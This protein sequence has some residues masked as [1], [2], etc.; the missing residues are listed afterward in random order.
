[1]PVPIPFGYYLVRR[2]PD[3]ADLPPGYPA[4]YV[5]IAGCLCKAIIPDTDN[6]PLYGQA[7]HPESLAGKWDLSLPAADALCRFNEAHYLE[8]DYASLSYRNVETARRVR[9]E[10]FNGRADVALIGLGALDDAFRRYPG[11]QEVSPF[12]ADARLLGFDL[13]EFGLPVAEGE[14]LKPLDFS[15]NSV[16]GLGCTL[17]CCDP[18]GSVPA[19]LG[20][21]L[22][23]FGFYPDAP[24]AIQAADLVNREHLGEPCRYLPFALFRCW[25]PL[26]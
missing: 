26:P 15:E 9:D 7:F 10:F 21:T 13:Y 11:I 23:R 16:M 6:I 19:R 14:E 25:P 2:S 5:T 3:A 1:M 12:P 24:A 20:I 8:I 18:N 17:L 4:E 22:N